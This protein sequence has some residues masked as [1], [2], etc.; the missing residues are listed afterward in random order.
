LGNFSKNTIVTKKMMCRSLPK[1]LDG[2]IEFYPQKGKAS[3]YSKRSPNDGKI[4]WENM[5]VWEIYNLIRG[6]TKPYP[7]AFG[8]ING[9]VYRI[10]KAQIFDESITYPDAFYGAVVEVFSKDLVVNCCDGLLLITDSELINE[11]YADK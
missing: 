2:S 8:E 5:D 9:K 3:Y 4:D 1:L 11:N 6:V 7:G 10:W